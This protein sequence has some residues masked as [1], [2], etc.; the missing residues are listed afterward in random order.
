MPTFHRTAHSVVRSYLHRL[1]SGDA[2]F[3]ALETA[4]AYSAV[5]PLLKALPAIETAYVHCAVT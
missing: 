4:K 2:V 5:L 3:A 1:E